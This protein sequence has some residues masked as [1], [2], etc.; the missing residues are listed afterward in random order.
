MFSYGTL[1]GAR[2]DGRGAPFRVDEACVPMA[3]KCDTC[4]LPVWRWSSGHPP[5]ITQGDALMPSSLLRLTVF[6]VQ[7]L[8]GIYG[9]IRLLG[10]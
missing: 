10:A 1:L 3:T 8:I 5:H 6:A 4:R 7:R 2:P 9:V